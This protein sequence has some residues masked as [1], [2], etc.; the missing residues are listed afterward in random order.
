MLERVEDELL[1]AAE[2]SADARALRLVN[3]I[4]RVRPAASSTTMMTSLGVSAERK[5]QARIDSAEAIPFTNSTERKLNCQ[6]K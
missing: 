3:C 5:A 2:I 4:D 1:C 6:A